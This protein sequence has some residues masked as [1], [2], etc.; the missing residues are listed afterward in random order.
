[1]R[2]TKLSCAIGLVVMAA[3]LVPAAQ[4]HDSSSPS[5]SDA[6]AQTQ[7]QDQDQMQPPASVSTAAQ[8]QQYPLQIKHA[9]GTTVIEHKPERI[10]TVAWANHEVPLALGVI[11]VGFPI[12]R[13]GDDD[14]DGMMPW[15]KAQLEALGADSANLFDEGD[16]IDFEAVAASN[17]DVILAA[18]SGLSEADYETL[19]KIAPVVA[20]PGPRWSSSWRD[21]IRLDSAGMGMAVE[22][23]ALI[24]RLEAQVA[25]NIASHPELKGKSIIVISHIDPTN[26]SRIVFYNDN[27]A[28]VRFFHELGLTSPPF[29]ADT[30]TDGRFAGEISAERLDELADVDIVLTYGGQK[31]IDRL[32]SHLLTSRLPAIQQ[33]AIVLLENGPMGTAAN[34]TPLSIPWVLDDYVDLLSVAAKKSD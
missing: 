12:Q 6:G 8:A 14:G 20:R 21:M 4:A 32:N 3:S 25:E 31:L 15:V 26:L 10:A 17:P 29:V 5:P 22:G 18:Y 7:A 30:A 13:F 1:M 11:P 33:D 23:D 9:F 16:G 28:R 2:L 19:S 24:Q 34:P 27:D